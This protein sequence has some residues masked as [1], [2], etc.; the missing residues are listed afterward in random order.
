MCTL[1]IPSANRPLSGGGPKPASAGAMVEKRFAAET[2]WSQA[3]A[4]TPAVAVVYGDADVHPPLTRALILH[5][6]APVHLASVHDVYTVS[7]HQ[8]LDAFIIAPRPSR[9]ESGEL[10]LNWLRAQPEYAGTPIVVLAGEREHPPD[11]G[12]AGGH[13]HGCV[14]GRTTS[15][16]W[17]IE[18]AIERV[19]ELIVRR[20]LDVGPGCH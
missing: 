17:V 16:E 14:A 9:G 15:A 3:A 10:V 2:G 6:F 5:G 1:W 7:R 20:A 8:R 12:A 19:K 18:R 11:G 13:R 4:S